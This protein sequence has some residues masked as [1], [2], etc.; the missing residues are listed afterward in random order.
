MYDSPRASIR[1][2]MVC[3]FVCA[4]FSAFIGWLVRPSGH[5]SG[6]STSAQCMSNLAQIGLAIHN[7]VSTFDCLP[8]A[9]TVDSRGKPMHSWRLLILPYLEQNK[10]PLPYNYNEPWNGPNNSKLAAQMP[11]VF[12]CP[13]DVHRVKGSGAPWT[14]YQ[15]VVGPGTAFPGPNQSAQIGDFTDGTSNT[16]MIVEVA[17]RPVHWMEPRDLDMTKLTSGVNGPKPSLSSNEAGPAVLFVDGHR[18]R[19]NPRTT[20]KEIQ[21]MASVAGG[22]PVER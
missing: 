15:A 1:K 22:E 7:Y 6:V 5:G 4:L 21:A 14:T 20:L 10:A 17:N 19:L 9:Y 12:A 13:T 16:I 8:P 11:R 18:Q 3:V 2:L